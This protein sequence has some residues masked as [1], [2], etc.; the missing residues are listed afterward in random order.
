MASTF[1][2]PPELEGWQCLAAADCAGGAARRH[3]SIE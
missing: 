3:H 2:H 1:P